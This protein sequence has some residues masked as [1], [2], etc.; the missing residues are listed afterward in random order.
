MFSVAVSFVI[1]LGVKV[2][3]TSHWPP[4]AVAGPVVQLFAAAKSPGFVPPV[5]VNALV[6]S[7]L[8][9]FEMKVTNVDGLRVFCS[10]GVSVITCPDAGGGGVGDRHAP[11]LA[12]GLM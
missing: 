12:A 11:A 10:V 7:T 8:P 1:V 9:W 2:T 5:N 6:K 3:S 4:P